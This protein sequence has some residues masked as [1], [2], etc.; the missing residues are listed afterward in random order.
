MRWL[1]FLFVL[2]VNA[3]PLYGV[4]VLGWSIGTVLLLFWLENLL[5][6]VFTSARIVLHRML[7]RRAGH[8]RSGQMGG[9]SVNGKPMNW[10]LLGE[11]AV[12][13]FP[14]TLVHGIFV[15]A[16]VF[17]IGANR[18]E[19]AEWRFSYEQFRLGALQMLGVLALDF[20]ID[21]LAMRT[22]SFAWIKAYAGQRTGRILILHLGIIF[23]MWAMAA[24]DSPI[25]VLYVI[26]ALKVLWELATSGATEKAA[27]LPERPPNWALKLADR[28]ARDKGGAQKMIEDWQG[29]NETRRREAIEDEAVRAP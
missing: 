15:V 1:N 12:V 25:G 16:I 20:L 23:G 11:Y 21:A 10:G 8:F 9:V 7:T 5:I 2:L 24:T 13:A 17:M 19:L 27:A 28:I 14:F 3:V 6:A 26:L 18:S 4:K 22:R 29:S